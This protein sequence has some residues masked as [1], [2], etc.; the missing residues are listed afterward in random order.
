MEQNNLPMK[1]RAFTYSNRKNCTLN[2]H[3]KNC[4]IQNVSLNFKKIRL[5]YFFAI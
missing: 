4:E 2:N 1:L 5:T 3:P